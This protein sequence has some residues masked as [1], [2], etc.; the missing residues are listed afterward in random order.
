MSCAWIFV[1]TLNHPGDSAPIQPGSGTL[2]HLAFP[3]IEI[4]FEREEIW[5]LGEDGGEIGGSGVHFPSTPVK[6]LVDLRSRANSHQYSS[7]YED[8]RPKIEDIKRSDGMKSA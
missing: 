6:Y 2:R 1:E 3:K 5:T 8:R 4:T 7:I